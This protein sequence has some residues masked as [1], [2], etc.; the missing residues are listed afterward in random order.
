MTKREAA[1]VSAY[2][3]YLIGEFSD[4]QAY[5]EEVM[6]RPIFTHELSDTKLITEIK[7][8]AAKDFKGIKITE[9][10]V[11]PSWFRKEITMGCKFKDRCPSYSGWCEG[12]N[13]PI[14]HCISYILD[15]YE[16][17]K[18]K[19]ENLE[20]IYHT[21]KE[22]ND[23]VDF[24]AIEKALG[25]RLFAWQKS[26]ILHQGFRRMGR[27][28]SEVI[29]MLFNKEQYDNPIDFTEPPRNKILRIF[30]Q[31]FREIW[32]K[33]RD[34][35]VEMRPVFWSRE[36]KEKYERRETPKVQI[37]SIYGEMRNKKGE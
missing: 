18:K 35:G 1:I 17:E 4:F 11:D 37:T 32:E 8:K 16:N 33:L 2:T 25:F 36:D 24:D 13:Y 9:T 20:W 15:D 31:Q 21:P 5:A 26:Y 29:K 19:T 10:K 23:S 14:G 30:R 12:I 34:A 28:T 22:N 7:N 27:T 6:E 3:G